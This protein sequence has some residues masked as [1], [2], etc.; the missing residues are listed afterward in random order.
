MIDEKTGK[1][2][3]FIKIKHIFF[4]WCLEQIFKE[5]N[6]TKYQNGIWIQF[7]KSIV[8][9]K[10]KLFCI[11]GDN[12]E[13]NLYCNNYNYFKCNFPCNICWTSNDYL[14]NE[15]IILK[16]KFNLFF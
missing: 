14:N 9:I 8:K 13:V 1:L 12:P 3:E 4:H 16:Y 11:I 2:N 7:R 6:D 5:L 10:F 15:N